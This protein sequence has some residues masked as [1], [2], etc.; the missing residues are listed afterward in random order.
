MSEE[1]SIQ[2]QT[3][4]QDRIEGKHSVH[5]TKSMKKTLA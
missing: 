5:Q 2:E 4:N 1:D 3:W